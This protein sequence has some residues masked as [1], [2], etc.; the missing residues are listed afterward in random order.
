M[1]LRIRY[2]CRIAISVFRKI[3]RCHHIAGHISRRYAKQTEHQRCRRRIMDTV[4]FFL[5]KEK[6]LRKI[7][8][9]RNLFQIHT[10]GTSFL[11]IPYHKIDNFLHGLQILLP[12]VSPQPIQSFHRNFQIFLRHILPVS[13][14]DL[15]FRLFR[16]LWIHPLYP[17]YITLIRD[18]FSGTGIT[19]VRLHISIVRHCTAVRNISIIATRMFSGDR[20]GSFFFRRPGTD[21]AVQDILYLPSAVRLGKCICKIVPVHR[22]PR[23]SLI[24]TAGKSPQIHIVCRFPGSIYREINLIFLFYRIIVQTAVC[25]RIMVAKQS[26]LAF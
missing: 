22:T 9:R 2:L 4:S 25:R 3:L 8:P 19:A 26:I 14:L 16:R 15:R 23:I 24:H 18:L 21:V 12:A 17:V 11:H 6:V 13:A 5:I 20:H 7:L 10:V 1:C